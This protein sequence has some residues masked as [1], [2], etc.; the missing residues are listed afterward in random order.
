MFHRKVGGEDSSLR[1]TSASPRNSVASSTRGP[2]DVAPC[3]NN[4]FARFVATG[5]SALPSSARM[6]DIFASP[7]PR[8]YYA[9]WS[10]TC[11]LDTRAG[12]FS[13][14]S[15]GLGLGFTSRR[16]GI[17]RQRN[18]RAASRKKIRRVIDDERPIACDSRSRRI[19]LMKSLTTSLDWLILSLKPRVPDFEEL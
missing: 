15:V 7:Q 9:G 4:G 19:T 11:S 1:G 14:C 3:S 16:A 18:L 8:R 6:D 12:V 13:R 5:R 17:R 2:G 10:N